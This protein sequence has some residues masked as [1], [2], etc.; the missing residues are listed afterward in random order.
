MTNS[1]A[2]KM[3]RSDTMS[4]PTLDRLDPALVSSPLLTRAPS[5]P[6]GEPSRDQSPDS[7]RN[8]PLAYESFS[9]AKLGIRP[10]LWFPWTFA[11]LC[12]MLAAAPPISVFLFLF[13][14]APK[15]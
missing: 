11:E 15:K 2:S 10:S 14:S 9:A 5:T 4:N 3:P 7:L 8:L 6:H 1:H 13:L 12:R